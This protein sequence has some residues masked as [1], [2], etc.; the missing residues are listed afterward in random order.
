M[1]TIGPTAVAG[2]QGCST[3]KATGAAPAGVAT[4]VPCQDAR[5]AVL[6]GAAPVLQIQEPVG[7]EAGVRASS[8]TSREAIGE[9]AEASGNGAARADQAA[10]RAAA[11]RGG[12]AYRPPGP[13]R[14]FVPSSASPAAVRRT[15]LALAGTMG[16]ARATAPTHP[17][18]AGT[19]PAPAAPAKPSVA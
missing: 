10:P 9:P 18:P 2:L 17:S 6:A 13:R 14:P 1:E 5:M 16:P 15:A 4:R 11:I 3:Q 12:A 8:P 7:A 19:V